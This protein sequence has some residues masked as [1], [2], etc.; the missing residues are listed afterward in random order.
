MVT[1][2][3]SHSFTK[4]DQLFP[5]PSSASSRE[6]SRKS[7]DNLLSYRVHKQT[8]KHGSKHYPL[9]RKPV[10]EVVNTSLV[11]PRT[12]DLLSLRQSTAVTIKRS[13]CRITNLSAVISKCPEI[14]QRA[15]VS[16]RLLTP[17]SVA[18]CPPNCN[19]VIL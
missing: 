16:A 6:L 17:P 2:T 18:C 8:H 4:F 15:R 12:S 7:T 1:I 14:Q 9:P 19:T 11:I 10:A 13:W 5:A 3:R